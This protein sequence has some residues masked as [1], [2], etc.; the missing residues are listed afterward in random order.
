MGRQTLCVAIVAMLCVVGVAYAQNGD[1]WT[2]RI[3]VFG[4]FHAR[5]ETGDQT[6]DGFDFR[7]MFLTLKADVNDRTTGIITLSRVGPGDPQRLTDYNIDLY[8]AFVDYKITDEWNVQVGQ[9]G[10][11]F[12][13]EGWES[14]SVRL[15]FERAL[16][17]EA[18]P[19]FYFKGAPD[20]GVWFR[21]NPTTPQEPLVVL[22]VCN[23][24]FRSDDVNTAK[25]V[26]VDVKWQR[27]WGLFGASWLNG[28]MG[29]DDLTTTAV[30]EEQPREALGAYVRMFPAPWGLQ[31]EWA[32]GEMLGTDR[33]GWY[34]QGMHAFQDHP[35]TIFA[36][37]EEFTSE[38]TGAGMEYQA[39]HVGYACQLDN[40]NEITVQ[41]TDGESTSW[42]AGVSSV[43]DASY[44]G[45]Q[46][47]YAF[48]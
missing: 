24:E 30:N 4:Y 48:Q 7:R 25:N 37:W 15:P 36:R 10:T 19:G 12:G 31:A 16:I 41:W 11:W 2:D 35:G 22:G 18:G 1:S 38:T 34:V 27:D 32:G 6:Q 13:L 46:W 44:G 40:S 21:R 42:A 45:V 8:H 29:Q 3:S 20:R 28:T 17:V 39:L 14:S 47:Q 23:G 26:S 43:S 9:V 5:Y 33:D